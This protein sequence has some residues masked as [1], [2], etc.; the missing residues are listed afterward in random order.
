MSLTLIE[1]SK[2]V[3][4]KLTVSAGGYWREDSVNQDLDTKFWNELVPKSGEGDTIHGELLRCASRIYRDMYQNGGSNIVEIND[5]ECD[6]CDYFERGG[7][8]NDEHLDRCSGT[9]SIDGY[10]NELFDFMEKW[11]PQYQVDVEQAKAAAL[12]MAW[13]VPIIF[14]HLVDRVIHTI[15]T[16]ENQ[17][18]PSKEPI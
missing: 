2:D 16:T 15:L 10:Y 12:E 6:R 14:D 11:M 8:D 1:N 17:Q 5:S 7:E 13:S 3:E 18:H 4:L 9:A